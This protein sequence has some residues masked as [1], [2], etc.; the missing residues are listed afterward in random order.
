[1]RVQQ[2]L[3][4]GVGEKLLRFDA[5]SRLSWGAEGPV[6][7]S[8]GESVQ[9]EAQ[10][11]GCRRGLGDRVIATGECGSYNPRDKGNV[12]VRMFRCPFDAWGCNRAHFTV[13]VQMRFYLDTARPESSGLV[14]GDMLQTTRVKNTRVH[15]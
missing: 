10:R 4:V 5:D 7:A 15:I 14:D 12:V 6:D 13:R 3:Q 1:M 9:A 8:H 11:H 2:G